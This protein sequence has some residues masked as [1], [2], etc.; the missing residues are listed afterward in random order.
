M[1]DLRIDPDRL[2]YGGVAAWS[3]LARHEAYWPQ[4]AL[5]KVEPV[6]AAAAVSVAEGQVTADQF[7]SGAALG[8]LTITPDLGVGFE[9]RR[10]IQAP[11]SVSSLGRGELQIAVK[12]FGPEAYQAL[13]I[14]WPTGKS[15]FSIKQCA[16]LYRGE[17]EQDVID[18][19]TSLTFEG[20]VEMHAGAAISGSADSFVT[21][22]LGASIPPWPHGLDLLLRFT[23]VR[24][25]RI[26]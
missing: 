23:Y 24:L 1:A 16:V 21:I 22:D 15:I 12:P 13:R 5:A 18:V 25:D 6:L 19:T 4:A 8:L 11:V 9:G 7:S 10:V 2:E 20:D 26:F 17:S 3:S 14:Q